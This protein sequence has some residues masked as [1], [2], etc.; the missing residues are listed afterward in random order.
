MRLAE[1]PRLADFYF[2]GLSKSRQSTLKEDL[3]LIKGKIVNDAMIRNAELTVKKHFHKKG[4]LNTTVKVVPVA[5]TINK[6]NVRLRFDIDLKLK[7]R[8]NEIAFE[9]NNEVPDSK[10]KSQLKKTHEYARFAIHRTILG[11][12]LNP[13]NL[14]EFATNTKPV[15]WNEVKEFIGKDVK[16]NVFAGSKLIAADFEEDK[17]KVVS[18]YNTQ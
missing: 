3:K 15:S 17:N 10:L 18:Y 6:G 5:D 9:G 11:T 14:K 16:L 13:R 7:V 8:I 2:T 4:F 1:R 12:F